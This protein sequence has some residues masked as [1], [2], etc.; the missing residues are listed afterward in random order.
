MQIVFYKQ[1]LRWPTFISALGICLKFKLA[2]FPLVG[3]EWVISGAPDEKSP[4][5]FAFNK[6]N[7]ET[8][9]IRLQNVLISAF[10]RVLYTTI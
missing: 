2:F 1:R 7:L 8:I 3:I 6:K 5:S 4:S 9:A 10:S